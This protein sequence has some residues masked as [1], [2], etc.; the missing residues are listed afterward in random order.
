MSSE[1]T[2]SS[3]CPEKF[4]IELA[5]IINWFYGFLDKV[6]KRIRC[7]VRSQMNLVELYNTYQE[8]FSHC[9]EMQSKNNCEKFLVKCENLRMQIYLSSQNSAQLQELR[10]EAV[11]SYLKNTLSLFELLSNEEFEMM[12]D[13]LMESKSCK[14]QWNYD[15]MDNVNSDLNEEDEFTRYPQKRRNSF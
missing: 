2:S 11:S 1:T 6:D 10:K 14:R 15:S 3:S 9:T 5:G 7:N 12:I 13:K 4:F 8:M